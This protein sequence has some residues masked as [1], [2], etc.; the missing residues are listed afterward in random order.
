MALA[1]RTRQAAGADQRADSTLHDVRGARRRA[2]LT[3]RI[4]ILVLLA[5]VILGAAGLF[6]VRSATVSVSQNGYT[7]TVTYPRIARSGLDV[8]F[9]VHVRHPGGFASDLSVAITSDYF[10][11]F[12]TQG[13]FPTPD[14]ESNDGRFI[15]LTFKKPPGTDFQVGYDT[16]IQPA[17]QIGKSAVVR[18]ETKGR[19]VAHTSINTWLL[20]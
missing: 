17:A 3:R 7:V 4:G 13:F 6:G 1:E 19:V 18:I 2:R 10:E 15:T 16:Y 8:P 9:R 20:P 12:E 11:M 14:S 5:I